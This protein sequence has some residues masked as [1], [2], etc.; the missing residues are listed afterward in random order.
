MVFHSKTVPLRGKG[1]SKTISKMTHNSKT[2]FFDGKNSFTI[3]RG[4]AKKG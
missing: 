3:K 2:V 1:P 4:V